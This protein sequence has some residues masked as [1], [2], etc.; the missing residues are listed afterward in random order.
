M[1]QHRVKTRFQPSD[2][3]AVRARFER[4]K[5]RA[6]EEADRALAP[7]KTPKVSRSWRAAAVAKRKQAEQR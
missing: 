4:I 2:R 1:L 6:I 5:K 7:V 3:E